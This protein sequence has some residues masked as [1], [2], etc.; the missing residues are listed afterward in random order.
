MRDVGQRLRR[1]LYVVP[2]VAKHSQGVPVEDLAAMLDVSRDH[3]LK[4]LD[5]LTQVGPPDGDPGEYLLVSVEEGRVFVDLP[6]RLTRPLRLTP[7]EGCSL[8][9]GIRTLRESGIAPFDDAL[10]SAELKLLKALGRDA[11]EAKK[12]ATGTIVS[13]PDQVVTGHLR[14]LV[15]AARMQNRVEIDYVS[16]SR[17]KAE[18]R[19]LDPYGIVHHAGEWYVVGHCHKRGDTRTFR[20]DRIAALTA[21]NARFAIPDD[22]DLEVYRREHL[23]VPS[24]DAVSVHVHLDPLATARVGSDWPLGKVVFNPDRSADIVIDCEG[25]EWI[26]GWVLGFGKHAS[27]V[28]PGEAHRAMRERVERT[29]KALGSLHSCTE[30]PVATSPA[31]PL[32]SDVAAPATAHSETVEPD[33]G[34]RKAA[35]GRDSA[36]APDR[37]GPESINGA[38]NTSPE[39]AR[40][41]AH[42]NIAFEANEGASGNS[43]A[44]AKSETETGTTAHGD[45]MRSSDAGA[46]ARDQTMA[47]DSAA[48]T[49]SITDGNIA[50]PAEPVGSGATPGD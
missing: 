5:M 38:E 1:L 17:H 39:Q 2:Y 26:T 25:F 7:A 24:A 3:L 9:L 20:V 29:E 33:S 6:Q 16:A 47:A 42:T 19:M 11:Q 30:E 43:R 21:T 32:L 10:A 15:T 8:L 23:Y 14:K 34:D 28:A 37:S 36:A 18:H 41:Q 27:I 48:S 45:N 46:G 35:D 49:S 40:D 12:L 13:E 31:W 50:S 4:D 22:F 44:E